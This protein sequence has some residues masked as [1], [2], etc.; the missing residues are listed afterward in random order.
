MF[1]PWKPETLQRHAEQ[2]RREQEAYDREPDRDYAE[3]L[4]GTMLRE[5]K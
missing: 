5:L 3:A 4:W 2:L 1:H